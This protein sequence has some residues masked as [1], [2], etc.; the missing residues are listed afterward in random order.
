MQPVLLQPRK[1]VIIKAVV[2]NKIFE[3]AMYDYFLSK[4]V[5]AKRP[6]TGV[7]QHDNENER[8]SEMIYHAKSGGKQYVL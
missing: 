4:N 1:S 5:T 8:D 7:M 3:I 6:S 2:F